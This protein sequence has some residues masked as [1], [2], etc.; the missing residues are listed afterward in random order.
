MND[1]M[2]DPDSQAEIRRRLE[3][4]RHQVY[5][6]ADPTS[7]PAQLHALMETEIELQRFLFSQAPADDSGLLLDTGGKGEKPGGVLMGK[8]T[9]GVEVKVYQRMNYVP[10]GIVHLL[11][12]K[13]APLVSF[14]VI[15]SGDQ[16]VR[17]RLISFV[18]GYSARSIDTVELS[19]AHNKEEVLQMPTFFPARLE[20]LHE[21]TRVTLHVR[22][23]DLD[24]RTQHH[25][26]FP[27]WLM[28]RTTASLAVKDVKTNQ[29]RDLTPYLAAWV[30]P[31]APAV[32]ELLRSAVDAIPEVEN[33]SG[34][35]ANTKGVEA[36]VKAIYMAV[37]SLG[38][39]YI[40][41]ILCSGGERD[42]LLQRIR[43]PSE[44]IKE[45][46]ANCIDGTVLLASLLEAASLNPALVIVPE[47]A[48]LG[49][50]TQDG[51]GEWDFL[52]TTLLGNADFA[53]AQRSGRTQAE[54][55]QAYQVLQDSPPVFCLQ[56][57][58]DARRN[59]G[60]IP[61]E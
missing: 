50:E 32:M 18:E 27:L 43:L 9:T 31:N 38:L 6:Q 46:S 36:Q 17:L 28:P 58:R 13:L 14:R 45:R 10:T 41:S 1:R 21:M 23:D 8:D 52:E 47:H 55:W 15:Y 34:Y 53:A 20:P 51:N 7:N 37:K 59:L 40:N 26:T 44:T 19:E 25:S 35:Q 29:W 48:F 4:L 30:T 42:E 57:V 54:K 61:M 11:D 60:I 16:F 56:P 5:A 12:P 2:K 22:I 39:C 33:L 3:Y 24:G 49:W